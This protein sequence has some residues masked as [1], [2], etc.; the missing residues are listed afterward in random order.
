M[1]EL[2]SENSGMEGHHLRVTEEETPRQK[3][4]G[5]KRPHLSPEEHHL[6]IKHEQSNLRTLGVPAD[7]TSDN[8]KA[9]C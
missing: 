9:F 8:F 2:S 1:T 3:L 4:P 5:I 7:V 6:E